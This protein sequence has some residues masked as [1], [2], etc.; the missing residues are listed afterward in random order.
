MALFDTRGKAAI[1]LK[2]GGKRKWLEHVRN[3]VTDPKLTLPRL[4]NVVLI[5]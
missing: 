1:C 3:E 5:T 2:L 4:R